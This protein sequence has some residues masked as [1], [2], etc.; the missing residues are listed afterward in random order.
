[1]HVKLEN[2]FEQTGWPA[3]VTKHSPPVDG[4][5]GQATFGA[6]KL[7]Q[8]DWPEQRQEFPHSTHCRFWQVCVSLQ[9]AHCAPPGPPQCWKAVP[10]WQV[11][12]AAQ[13]PCGHVAA[14][15][16]AHVWLMQPCPDGH[17]AQRLPPAPQAVFAVPGWQ[18]ALASQQPVGQ[19]SASQTHWPLSQRWPSWQLPQLPPQP[20]GPQCRPAQFGVQH[21]PSWQ[22]C[23]PEQVAQGAPARPHAWGVVPGSQTEPLAAQQPSGQVPGSQTHRPVSVTQ[24]VPC[25]QAPHVPPHPFGPHCLPAQFGVQHSPRKSHSVAPAGQQM[26]S[27]QCPS[28]RSFGLGPSATGVKTHWSLTQAPTR[29]V[30]WPQS[31]ALRQGRPAPGPG[32]QQ[33][34]PRSQSRSLTEPSGMVVLQKRAP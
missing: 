32:S 30:L 14:L 5:K 27:Q 13:Q 29:Q 24:A 4:T 11:W 34:V 17:V 8:M 16:A 20:S 23:C 21:C 9:A 28:H 2:E 10:G 25:G 18:A 33:A 15:Q 1:M 31:D 19:L 6:S 3:S 12:S 22:T 26:P 7:S